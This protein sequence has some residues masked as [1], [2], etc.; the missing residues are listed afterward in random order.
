[1]QKLSRRWKTDTPRD[2]KS[3]LVPCSVDLSLNR[4]QRVSE[5]VLSTLD[6]T[7]EGVQPQYKE[8]QNLRVSAKV[9]IIKTPIKAGG[10]NA[11]MYNFGG[12][13]WD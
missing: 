12:F 13:V 10:L 2:V 8:G 3:R 11:S 4:P 9:Y 1:M 5:Q 7:P 6:N